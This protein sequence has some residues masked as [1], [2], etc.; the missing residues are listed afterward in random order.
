MVPVAVKE[1]LELND[2]QERK[3]NTV[4]DTATKILRRVEVLLDSPRVCG[5][6]KNLMEKIAGIPSLKESIDTF[7]DNV[8]D[9]KKQVYLNKDDLLVMKT[10]KKTT[11]AV[12]SVIAGVISGIVAL[13][14]KFL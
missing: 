11:I 13:L 7:N 6:H 3:G 10:E 9:L 8:A 1:T 4:Q 5:E 2:N 14:V 12:I